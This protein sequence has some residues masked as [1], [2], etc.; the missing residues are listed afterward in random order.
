MKKNPIFYKNKLYFSD[1][2]SRR[3]Y[4]WIKAVPSGPENSHNVVQLNLNEDKTYLI[5]PYPTLMPPL[6]KFS[7][8]SIKAIAHNPHIKSV[9]IYSRSDIEHHVRMQQF[10]ELLTKMDT[11]H[12][13]LIDQNLR[14]LAE[15]T[16]FSET[17][18]QE[19][20]GGFKD[21][22]DYIYPN[23]EKYRPQD[24]SPIKIV[25]FVNFENELLAFLGW[26]Y[27]ILQKLTILYTKFN[28]SDSSSN[29]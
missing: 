4:F 3:T 6:M 20:H 24:I 11:T 25:S 18:A 17:Y 9:S 5:T 26:S 2:F 19:Y 1:K 23:G 8:E 27:Y 16:G 12:R 14:K 21:I 10:Q 29:L 15:T 28:F 13:Q 22:R 7:P